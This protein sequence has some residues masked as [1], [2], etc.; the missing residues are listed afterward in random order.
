[1]VVSGDDQ[2]VL[3]EQAAA[4]VQALGLVIVHTMV[5]SGADDELELTLHEARALGSLARLGTTKMGA[6]A[7]SI[8]LHVS[9]AT[10]TVDRLV[11]KGLAT[12]TSADDDRRC[13]LVSLS[14]RGAARE[15][16]L[17][18]HRTER[19]RALLANLSPDE[20]VVLLAGLQKLAPT[21]PCGDKGED[22]A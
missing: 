12:R 14:E 19:A 10:R 11:K 6:F 15:A 4:L 2:A 1:M 13:V 21:K 7:C 17:L 22:E 3:N 20:R 5:V 18:R 8:G 16:C 9:T